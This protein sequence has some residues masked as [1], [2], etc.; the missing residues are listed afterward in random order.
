M[1]ELD[2][3]DDSDNPKGALVSILLRS[4]PSRGG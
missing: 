4:G 3:V 2:A 1:A